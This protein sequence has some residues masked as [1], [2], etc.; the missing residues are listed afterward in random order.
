MELVRIDTHNKVVP[1]VHAVYLRRELPSYSFYQVQ[2]GFI[3]IRRCSKFGTGELSQR[4][5]I[6][7]IAAE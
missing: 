2:V 3:P 7:A 4:V 6:E 5:E 1:L